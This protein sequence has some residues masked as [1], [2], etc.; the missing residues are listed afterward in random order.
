M[1]TYVGG[2]S[3][4]AARKISADWIQLELIPLLQFKEELSTLLL[5]WNPSDRKIVGEGSESILNIIKSA[6]HQGVQK[7][8][9]AS[10]LSSLELIDP[11]SNPSELAI[12][13]TQFFWIIPTPVQSDS[14]LDYPSKNSKKLQ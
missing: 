14:V 9:M 6:T 5:W 7:S 2:Y 8:F 10:D 13:L 3:V 1:N 11:L 4:M 12:I